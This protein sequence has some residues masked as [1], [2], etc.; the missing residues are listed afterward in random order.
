MANSKAKRTAAEISIQR[1]L[2]IGRRRRRRKFPKPGSTAG[3]E[4]DYARRI[5]RIVDQVWG[6]TKD[7]RDAMPGLLRK[8]RGVREDAGESD[9]L[10][11]LLEELRA[12][13]QGVIS[14]EEIEAL[15]L[16]FAE[17]TETYQRIQMGRQVQA[18]LGADVFISN[19][20]LFARLEGFAQENAELIKDIGEELTRKVAKST[21]RAIQSGTLHPDLA[22]EL[23]NA[24][25]FARNRAKLVAR[26]QVGKLYSALNRDR[27]RDLGTEKY[28]WRTSNDERVRDSHQ[29]FNGETYSWHKGSPEGHP[30]EPILCRCYAEPIFDPILE[31]VDDE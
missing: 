9:A 16:E 5:L 21:T 14:Q 10:K 13:M 15:A 6:L 22:K 30:G 11:R 27:Y 23:E 4:R 1:K 20:T 17:R 29:G 25:G 8:A 18:V 24:Y 31:E 3:I 7:L 12:E 28:I 26:D 2:G 19:R